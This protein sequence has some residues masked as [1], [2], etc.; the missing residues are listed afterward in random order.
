M[1]AGT[2]WKSFIK[3]LTCEIPRPPLPILFD[4][5]TFTDV[6]F[7]PLAC[8]MHLGYNSL[9]SQAIVDYIFFS[10]VSVRYRLVTKNH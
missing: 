3:L 1:H 10:N 6:L 7:K 9:M 2:E 5:C 8:G 4:S